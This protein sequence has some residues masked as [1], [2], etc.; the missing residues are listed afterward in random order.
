MFYLGVTLNKLGMASCALK[1]WSVAHKLDRH[2][3]SGK[4][5]RR[6]A[7]AYGMAKQ[8]SEELDDWKAFYSVQLARYLSMKKSKRLGTDAEK[9][10]IWE[11]ILDGWRE[12]HNSMDLLSLDSEDKLKLFRAFK[13]VFPVFA[14]PEDDEPRPIAVDF[15]RQKR[16]GLDDHCFCGSGLPYKLCCGRTPGE[17]ELITGVI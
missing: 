1:S 6:F 11:L 14:L 9:D 5:L 8:E 16:V 2:S 3:Y 4:F 13:I 12:L 15:S 17:D 7:N 10:M